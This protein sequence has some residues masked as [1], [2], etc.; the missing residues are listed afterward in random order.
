VNLA[1]TQEI[2]SWTQL[3]LG[4]RYKIEPSEFGPLTLRASVTNALDS[5]AWSGPRFGG[6]VARDPLTVILSVTADF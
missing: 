2:P 6:V 1:N 5:D 3:D 4:A